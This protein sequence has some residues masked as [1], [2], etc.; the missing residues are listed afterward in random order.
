M[1][2]G[3]V[4]VHWLCFIDHEYD[5]DYDND[6]DNDNEIRY[7]CEWRPQLRP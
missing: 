1:A 7:A 6:N 3:P 2:M 5:Y 4:K